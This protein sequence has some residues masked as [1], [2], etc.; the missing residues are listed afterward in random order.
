MTVRKETG[1]QKLEI[2]SE[3]TV[4]LV[5][6]LLVILSF[7]PKKLRSCLARTHE[8]NLYINSC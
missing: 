5:K 3:V 1:G 2:F 4:R 7:W 8:K 6:S